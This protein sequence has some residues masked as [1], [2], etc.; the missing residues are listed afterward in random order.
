M[1]FIKFKKYFMPV[2]IGLI[3]LSGIV[4]RIILYSFD[5][6]FWNDECALAFNLF[7]AGFTDYFKVLQYSQ[8]A[9]PL[10]LMVSSLFLKIVPDIELALRF[11]PLLASIL[12]MPAFYILSKKVLNKNIAVISALIIFCANYNLIYY[13]QE[14]K[15]YSSDIFIFLGILASYFYIDFKKL[16]NKQ[17]LLVSLVYSLL[18]W[19]SF[20]SLFALFTILILILIN[21]K[22]ELKKY[23][24]LAAPIGISFI[25]FYINQHHLS[26]NSFLH[27][28]WIN[29]FIQKD[30][31]NI[32]AVV[33]NNF[34]YSF[35]KALIL[36]L[37]FITGIIMTLLNFKKNENL[38]LIIPYM[39]AL[40]LSYL[41][42][43]PLEGRIALYLMPILILFIAKVLDSINFK[44]KIF[45]YSL[46]SI[47]FLI[48]VIPQLIKIPYTINTKNLSYSDI[49]TSMKTA[50]S[51]MN[52]DD[53]LY[54]PL[55]TKLSFDF[56]Y[57]I[58]GIEYNNIVYESELI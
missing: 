1:N 2:I 13:A 15:Q 51:L 52:E 16:N 39:L 4:F 48:I 44:N 33:M 38:I 57:K 32:I 6:P 45:E 49:V 10:F 35:N 41:S 55:S 26:A 5:K 37:I 31:S 18:I 53:I 20:T 58:L 56:Y 36:F 34:F 11:I 9:P 43:Y 7:D 47:I 17:T 24:L 29:G 30:L 12:S 27:E 19:F 54:V 42:I 3:I 28:Y 14:F 50:K 22:D 23:T 40:V 25:I 8:A 21:N 46:I